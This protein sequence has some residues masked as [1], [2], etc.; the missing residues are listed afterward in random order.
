MIKP[1]RTKVIVTKIKSQ[2]CEFLCHIGYAQK[3]IM[4]LQ[5]DVTTYPEVPREELSDHTRV[6]DHE[7]NTI[8]TPN[9]IS[10]LK[11]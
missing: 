3:V 2:F 9:N 6:E 11:S 8:T 4:I 1:N 7:E 10:H 5:K